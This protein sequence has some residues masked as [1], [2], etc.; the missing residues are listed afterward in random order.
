M[1]PVSEMNQKVLD[2]L[3][4]CIA[5]GRLPNGKRACLLCGATCPEEPMLTGLCIPGPDGS[6][7]LGCSKERIASGGGRVV[8]YQLCPSCYD[9]PNLDDEVEAKILRQAGVQ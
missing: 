9:R 6:R 4:S 1:K 5:T 3:R 2:T 7:R 8:I